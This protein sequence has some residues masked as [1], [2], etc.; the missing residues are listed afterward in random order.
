MTAI[1]SVD[2]FGDELI[3]E[4]TPQKPGRPRHIWVTDVI[5]PDPHKP[6]HLYLSQHVDGTWVEA[7]DNDY[8][9]VWEP[10]EDYEPTITR[11]MYAYMDEEGNLKNV[12]DRG[13][14]GR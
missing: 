8:E 13:R 4:G 10:R 3:R 14:Q 7:A 5:A 2:V 1:T 9:V 11:I 6:G 12:H